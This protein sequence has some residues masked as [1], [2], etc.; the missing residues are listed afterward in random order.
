MLDLLRRQ[1]D[2]QVTA[3]SNGTGVAAVV[4]PRELA[5]AGEVVR[6]AREH[7][8]RLVTV[9]ARTK[10]AWAA[11]GR[12]PAIELDMCGL[13]RVV[14]YSPED[15]TITVEAGMTLGS[16]TA[17][18]AR[19]HQRLTLD[20]PNGDRATVGGVLAANDSGPVR[21]A[22]G[23]ARDI[24]IGMSMIEPDGGL[25]RSGG[26]VVK[27]V[28]GYDLHKLYIGS[29]GTLG[30]IATVTF[31]L[32][33]QPEARGMVVLTPRD[34][35]EAEDMIA[36]ALA[37]DTR[38]TFVELLNGRM[39]G[40]LKLLGRTTLVIGFE[41][42]AD[43]VSW[44]CSAIV[45]ALGGVPLSETHS[46]ALYDQL[47]QAAGGEAPAGFKASLLS[48]EVC[49]FVE[50]LDRLPLRIIAR[51]GN[52]VVHGLADEPLHDSE[53]TVLEGMM[54]DLEGS[55][56]VRGPVPAVAPRFGRPRGDAFLSQAIQ[57][58][59]DPLATFAPER[60]GWPG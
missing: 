41:E 10:Q 50:R 33:P 35:V 25:V 11:P 44:Q 3:P 51:A 31:K 54:A 13:S 45:K 56:Q 37:G 21:F 19:N 7:G 40:R 16:L 24:V 43:A 14:E 29:F 30:P 59:F 38:P 5:A 2:D 4:R 1:F 23:T 28:A 22:Y 47:R 26:K 32:R 52:G 9:G 60:M 6:L 34:A 42:N 27:N 15:M 12:G 58:R 39:A 46:A 57:R 18:L 55:L 53:W 48:S 49:G 36:G 8:H 20:P 17:V